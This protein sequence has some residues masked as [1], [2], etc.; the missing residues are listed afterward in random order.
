MSASQDAPLKILF[1]ASEAEPFYKVGGLG[2]Y[3]GSLPAALAATAQKNGRPLDIRVGLPFH[4][5]I[6]VDQSVFTKVTDLKVPKKK[7]SAKGSVF[8]HTHNGVPYYFIRRAG[9]AGGYS[10]VYSASPLQDARKYIFFSLASLE[11][12]RLLDW[13]PDVIHANDWHTAVAVYQLRHALREH[14]FFSRTRSLLVIHNLPF[15]GAGTGEVLDE[16][17]IPPLP[18]TGNLPSWSLHFPLVLGLQSADHITAV[19][20]SYAQELKEE[21]F[22]NG[23]KGFFRENEYRTSGILNGID[24]QKWDPLSDMHLTN[25]FSAEDLEARKANKSAV[26]ELAGFDPQDE[27]PLL[28]AVTRLDIQKG[29]DLLMA[30]IPQLTDLDWNMI[31]LGTGDPEYEK[32]FTKLQ[33]CYPERL[34]VFLEFNASLSHKL[35]AG[36]DVFLMPSRY[37][38]CGLSQMI[39]MR[40]GCIPLA[41][42]VGGLRDTINNASDDTR[43]G[44]LFDHASAEAFSTALRKA[45]LAYR[46]QD[47]WRRIQLR[48][49]AQDFSWENSAEKYL[50]LYQD[51]LE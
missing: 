15:M 21:E 8:M 44:F 24:T 41:R 16:F 40:Y 34:R 38:P 29:T 47:Q 3:A 39:A 31:V 5:S 1:L 20:P 6:N 37:E 32:T 18:P 9:R 10:N 30:A 2:D 33:S 19:S 7:G 43:T 35:Y 50:Q 28:V 4:Q 25:N 48:A 11:L 26:L 49:M 51:L 22:G 42:A 17:G 36:G 27:R 14:S 45:L 23:L 13:Q 46:D 12:T